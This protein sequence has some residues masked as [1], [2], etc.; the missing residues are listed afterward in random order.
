MRHTWETATTSSSTPGFKKRFKGRCIDINMFYISLAQQKDKKQTPNWY[1]CQLN[2]RGQQRS[3]QFQYTELNHHVSIKNLN[4]P[5]L[6]IAAW[7]MSAVSVCLSC[8]ASVLWYARHS[9]N[10]GGICEV[11]ELQNRLRKRLITITRIN[12][13]LSTYNYRIIGN[14]I[15]RGCASIE[16]SD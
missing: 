16:T 13:L 2:S 4:R 12:V 15:M 5:E 8:P 11:E 7:E 6:K 9:Q 3:S 1:W 14:I 10:K